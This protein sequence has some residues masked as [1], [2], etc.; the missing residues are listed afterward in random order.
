MF[1]HVVFGLPPESWAELL[2]NS[3]LPCKETF[4]SEAKMAPEG[5]TS[6]DKKNR[7]F[8]KGMQPA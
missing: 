7:V 2:D 5:N 8:G 6:R 1:A 4:E 3:V